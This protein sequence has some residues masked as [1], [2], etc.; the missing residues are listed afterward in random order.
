MA[1]DSAS[2]QAISASFEVA[3]VQCREPLDLFD[4]LAP[5]RTGTRR[6]V[7][8]GRA[9]RQPGQHGAGDH[10]LGEIVDGQDRDFLP[11]PGRHTRV[12]AQSVERTRCAGQGRLDRCQVGQ[13]DSVAGERGLLRRADIEARDAAAAGQQLRGQRRANAGGNARDGVVRLVHVSSARPFRRN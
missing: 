2:V 3:R 4:V 9:G 8:D 12:V 6:H 11:W 13:V 5:A 10:P 1:S 7:D